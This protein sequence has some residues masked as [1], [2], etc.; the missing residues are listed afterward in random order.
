M[1][2]CRTA[3]VHINTGVFQSSVI[4]SHN[5]SGDGDS[6]RRTAQRTLA[7]SS[8]NGGKASS[9]TRRVTAATRTA[10]NPTICG[11]ISRRI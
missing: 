7:A 8:M 9:L 10:A 3:V 1:P 5:V 2:R 11:V 4:G 6:A